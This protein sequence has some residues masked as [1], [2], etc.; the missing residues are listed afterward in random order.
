[1]LELGAAKALGKRIVAV[2]PDSARFANSTVAGKL[3][4]MLVVDQDPKSPAE[5]ARKILEKVA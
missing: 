3:A 1:M 2:L 5:M 4:D